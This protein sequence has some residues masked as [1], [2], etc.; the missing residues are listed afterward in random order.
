MLD[1][2]KFGSIFKR[3]LAYSRR[4]CSSAPEQCDRLGPYIGNI[5]SAAFLKVMS[6]PPHKRQTPC[7]PRQEG[8][9]YEAA[10]EV[11]ILIGQDSFNRKRTRTVAE[12]ASAEA[13][14]D[15]TAQVGHEGR[16]RSG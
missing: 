12:V 3:T 5:N 8:N 15:G 14:A 16:D 9:P 13:G 10:F 1:E 7:S 4:L 2:G 11:L 6:P